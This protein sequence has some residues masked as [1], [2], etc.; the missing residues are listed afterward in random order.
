MGILDGELAAR[1][2]LLRGTGVVVNSEHPDIEVAELPVSR[3]DV[4]DPQSAPSE[5]GDIPPDGPDC[6]SDAAAASGLLRVR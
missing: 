5:I 4:E 6:C 2:L 3:S 1:R